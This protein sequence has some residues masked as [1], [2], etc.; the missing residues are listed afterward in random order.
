MLRKRF[1]WSAILRHKHTHPQIARKISVYRTY[2]IWQDVTQAPFESN[3][4]WAKL[5]NLLSDCKLCNAL[6]GSVQSLVNSFL[7]IRLNL[8]GSSWSKI[9]GKEEPLMWKRFGKETIRSAES[10]CLLWWRALKPVSRRIS[11]QVL[12]LLS[13][14]W[15]FIIECDS[16]VAK[17]V[18]K[19]VTIS[20]AHKQNIWIKLGEYSDFFGFRMQDDQTDLINATVR[21]AWNVTPS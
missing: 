11:Q 12:T 17:R 3:T 19:T 6:I 20:W 2:K 14:I 18:P 4:V 8:V 13:S 16:V 21:Q 15:G 5:Q 7:L 10:G 9:L 1:G